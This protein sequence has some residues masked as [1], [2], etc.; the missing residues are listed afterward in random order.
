M[1]V[2]IVDYGSTDSND[3]NHQR[4]I[5]QEDRLEFYE[6]SDL[7][8]SEAV[9]FGVSMCNAPLIAVVHPEVSLSDDMINDCL[10]EMMDKKP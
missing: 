6:K 3:F 7:Q 9:S 1:Q 8:Y 5:S 2:V 10:S 4:F